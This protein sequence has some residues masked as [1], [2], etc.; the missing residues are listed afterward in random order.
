MTTALSFD[1]QYSGFFV[2]G[3]CLWGSGFTTNKEG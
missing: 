1:A 2:V 3:K